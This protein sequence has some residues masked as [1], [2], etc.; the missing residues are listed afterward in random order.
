MS[1]KVAVFVDGCFWHR[2]PQHA[3]FPTKNGEW[4]RAKLDRTYERDRRNDSALASAGWTVIRVWEHED[5]EEAADRIAL[6][7]GRELRSIP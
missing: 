7:L 3:S 4:W 6:V 5:V 1:A 2:C